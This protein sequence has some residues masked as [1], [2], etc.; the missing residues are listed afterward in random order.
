M[1][2]VKTAIDGLFVIEL[3][4]V[5]DERGM[6]SRT[7]CAKEFEQHGLVS[8]V[9]Q[10]NVSFNQKAGTLRGLHYQTAPYDEA[11]LVRCTAGAI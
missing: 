6:F 11:K 4:P 7:F 9:A 1:K 10:C 3:E 8:K 5:N 2:F